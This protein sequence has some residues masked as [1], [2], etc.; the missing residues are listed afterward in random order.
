MHPLLKVIQILSA[1][2]LVL[3]L[4]A[5]SKQNFDLPQEQQAFGQTVTYN[6]KVDILLM[7]DNSS[8][9]LQYQNKFAQQVPMML[10]KLDQLK[11]DYHIAVTTSDM[12]AAGTGGKLFGMPKFVT[13]LTPNLATTLQAKVTVGQNGS[14]LERGLESVRTLLEPAS[15]AS[16]AKDFFR[17]DALLVIIFLTNEDD[18]SA[19][20]V[21]SYVDFF[22]ALK[23]P[24]KDNRN[25]QPSWIANFIGVVSI[26]SNCNTTADF[27]EAGL[28]YMGLVEASGGLNESICR[29]SL[30]QAVS[31]IRARI[32]EVLTD[33]YLDRKPVIET[34][35]VMLNGV[36][37]P[38]ESTNGWSYEA[39]GNFIRFN[40]TSVP[41]AEDQIVVDFKPAEAT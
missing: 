30:D 23:P 12:R 40:G 6:N 10:N 1:S 32:I 34:I 27:K 31:N 15:L 20:T 9:M 21:Q 19:G 38:N 26:D 18:Y 35:T 14:D 8:S 3:T 17:Q 7:M 29:T 2:V 41:G 5:C 25:N 37:V 13:P 39:D 24:F 16:G 36:A 11:M 22:D 4:G 33:F 28:R